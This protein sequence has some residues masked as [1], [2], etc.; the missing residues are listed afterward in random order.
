MKDTGY[1]REQAAELLGISTRTLDRYLKTKKI[2]SSQIRGRVRIYQT[3]IEK[4]SEYLGKKI[5]TQENIISPHTSKTKE[6]TVPQGQ[7]DHLYK[8]LYEETKNE[9]KQ[10]YSELNSA[11]YRLGQLEEKLH[12]SIPLLE[13]KENTLALKEAEVNL[14]KK[15]EEIQQK[16]KME[17]LN[18]WIFAILLLGMIAL[19]PVLWILNK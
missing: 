4:F 1:S 3:D 10:A 5:I 12:N 13:L 17:R 15:S 8:N 9:L 2:K 7:F 6:M 16:L 11:N 18:K 19:Q 14:E